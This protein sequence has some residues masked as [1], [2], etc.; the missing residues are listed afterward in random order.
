MTKEIFLLRQELWISRG[1]ASSFTWYVTYY[2]I[3]VYK[4]FIK[5]F[6]KDQDINNIYKATFITKSAQ[7][8]FHASLQH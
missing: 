2:I 5:G 8:L 4:K 1:D 3:K 6:S 7:D